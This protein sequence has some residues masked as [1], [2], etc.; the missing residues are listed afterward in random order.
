MK[1]IRTRED[2]LNLQQPRPT[3]VLTW[4][5]IEIICERAVEKYV[6]RHDDY[7]AKF[8]SLPDELEVRQVA[9]FLKTTKPTIYT[10]IKE[11]ILN[12][13]DIPGKRLYITREQLIQDCRKHGL[14][15]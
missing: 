4:D 13:V 11:G 7:R 14:V 9:E 5:Q 8:A 2:F 15:H 12:F 10:K 1:G 6:N 3:I